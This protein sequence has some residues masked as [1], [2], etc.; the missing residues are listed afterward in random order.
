M[1]RTAPFGRCLFSTNTQHP[2][3]NAHFTFV[4]VAG[5]SRGKRLS[6][7]RRGGGGSPSPQ[8]FSQRPGGIVVN[9]KTPNYKIRGL[10][11]ESLERMPAFPRSI[12]VLGLR[13]F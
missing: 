11:P 8:A 7:A 1:E 4:S 12:I 6:T 5:F 9:F 3:F 13:R 2:D 10:L